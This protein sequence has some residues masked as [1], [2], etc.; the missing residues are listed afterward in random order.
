MSMKDV[1]ETCLNNVE[2]FFMDR[3]TQLVD[4]NRIDDADAIHTEF[5]VEN[6]NSEEWLFISDMTNV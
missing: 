6:P 1:H 4:N 2:E 5:V 3:V